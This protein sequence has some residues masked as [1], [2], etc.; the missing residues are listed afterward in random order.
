MLS[1]LVCT[2]LAMAAGEDAKASL[3]DQIGPLVR[4][5]NA[6]Q[7]AERE[8]AERKLLQLGP[9]ALPHLPPVGDR[10]SAETAM[11]L[12]RLQQKLLKLQATS[13]AEPTLVTIKSA[14][15]PLSEALKLISEQTGNPVTD[16]RDSRGEDKSDPKVKVDFDKTSYWRALDNVLDQAGLTLYG[17]AGQRG[18]FVVSRSSDSRPRAEANY[19]GL[20]RFEA[21]RFEA[22]RELRGGELG[23]LKFFMEISWEPRL[24][25]FAILQPLAQVTAVGD[26]GET[27][28]L[29]NAEAEPEALVREG[30]S[31]AELEVPLALPKRSMEKIKSLKGKLTAL[32]PGPAQD[33]RFA[34]IPITT[35]RAAAQ[36][37]E[38]RKAGATVTIDQLRKNNQVWELSMRLKFEGPAS[39]M[40]SHRGWILENEAR[41]EDKA[42]QKI[43]P[44]GIEQTLQSKDEVGVS[45]FFDLKDGP[46]KLVF[47][48]R[49]P[50][51]VL[52]VPVEYEF[53]D[54][55]L[56]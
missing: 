27:I 17:F 2:A 13:A 10:T 33:F 6:A 47:V 12:S 37:V 23:S 15:M 26:N 55:Q 5:L 1:L 38:Q 11:R 16:Y 39:A 21:V 53:H 4:Q 48:Y 24:Q 20:F 36:R 29:G 40:E 19:A 18:A 51:M 56:P 8:E 34:E 7:L 9:E 54:L 32:V 22:L 25:P 52:E 43:E 41:F 31:A 44:A 42:G 35:G 50:V 28:P 45:Y 14:E 46:Q 30:M 3:A 49:T